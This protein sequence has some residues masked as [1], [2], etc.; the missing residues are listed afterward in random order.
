MV[1]RAARTAAGLTALRRV[2]VLVPLV[3][4]A[5]YEAIRFAGF[6]QGW[7]IVRL[8]FAGNIAL[9]LL[10]TRTPD[11]EQIQVA[12]RALDEV[13]AAERRLPG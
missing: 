12:I 5:S 7:P 8:L 2:V 3:A 1:R 11:D 10:T 13:I 4:G 6:H 9:Q